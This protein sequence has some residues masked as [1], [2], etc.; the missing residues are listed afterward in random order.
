M[1]TEEEK[2][3]YTFTRNY[4][5]R[6]GKYAIYQRLFLD[7]S[8]T[9]RWFLDAG[10]GPGHFTP[11]VEAVA[12]GTLVSLDPELGPLI[13]S[14]SKGQQLVIQGDMQS[15]PFRSNF[16]DFV[17]CL[18]V[19]EHVENDQKIIDE[20]YRILKPGGR[21]LITVPAL[22]ILWGSHD[23]MSGHFRRYKKKEFSRLLQ[24]PGFNL[25]KL[26]YAQ[27]IFFF[28][29]FVSRRLKKMKG[30]QKRDA[31][32]VKPIVNRLLHF[33]VRIEYHFLKYFSLPLGTNLLGI[34][35]KPG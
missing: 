6:T 28:P 23:E 30:Q 7:Y 35:E 12:Q 18:E 17:F 25:L 13:Y 34:V 32:Q 16:Y 24:T 21:A 1:I 22:P 27:F 14:R 26:T 10:A 31:F 20:I 2:A 11:W 5:W 8:S 9:G 33:L 3:R 15:S 4:W 19:C 29:L